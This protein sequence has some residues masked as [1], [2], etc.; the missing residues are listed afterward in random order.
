MKKSILLL[1]CTMLISFPLL[2]LDMVPE[3]M[4]AVL[5]LK[6]LSFVKNFERGI[7]SEG[8]TIGIYG[9]N[10]IL[11][12]FDAAAKKLPFKVNFVS[13]PENLL[14]LERVQLLYIPRGSSA[15]VFEK[16]NAMTKRNKILTVSGDPNAGLDFNCTLSFYINNDNPKIL[17]NMKSAKEEDINFS[18]KVLG[19]ADVRNMK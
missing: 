16:I 14:N 13:I 2:S 15:T 6:I 1:L 10:T 4:Q 7:Q 8:I 17:I 5:I 11:P 19:L 12:A 3:S 18:S 9:A